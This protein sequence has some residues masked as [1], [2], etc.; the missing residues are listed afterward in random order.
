MTENEVLA[1]ILKRFIAE[2][3]GR[4]YVSLMGPD[5]RHGPSYFV[6][7]ARTELNETERLVVS[8]FIEDSD[9]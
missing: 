5:L 4:G 7:D 1:G 3:E 8:R 2:R 9:A 6:I